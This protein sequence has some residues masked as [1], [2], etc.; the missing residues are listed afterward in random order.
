MEQATLFDTGKF[1]KNQAMANFEN[2]VQDWLS[3][4]RKVEEP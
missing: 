2:K 3:Q 4:A 1:L